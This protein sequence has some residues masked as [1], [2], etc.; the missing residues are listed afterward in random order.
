MAGYTKIV[1]TIWND[2][3]YRTLD[4]LAQW[5]YLMLVS[6]PDI[7]HA[8]VLAFT[9]GRWATLADGLTPALVRRAV[10]TLEAGR[11]IVV[12]ANT[13]ELWVRSY[14]KYDEGH[15]VPNIRT[16][17]GRACDSISSKRLRVMAATVASTLG[18]TLS[19]TL[20]GWVSQ[21]LQPIPET[22]AAAA[23]EPLTVPA[24]DIAAAA[25]SAYIDHRVTV[26]QP[27]NPIGF[28]KR[29]E[30]EVPDEHGAAI[31]QHIAS[32]NDATVE[33]IM[34]AV[35]GIAT[36]TPTEPAPQ[37]D[38]DCPDCSGYG[39][40]QVDEDGHGTFARCDCHSLMIGRADA[41]VIEMRRR[42]Q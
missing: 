41:D 29:L 14:M 8:G 32:R 25:I 38:P 5:T 37:F 42:V 36:S 12:D 2:D 39:I 35:F 28:R 13:E 4:P 30:R 24:T 17:I 21:S 26:F 33:S 27:T 16:A 7:S 20:A 3:D 6:Q 9:P 11:F 31:Q 15:K 23:A 18:V 19:E 22:A 1:R 10:A 34:S 40:V